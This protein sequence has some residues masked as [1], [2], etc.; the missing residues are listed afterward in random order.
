MQ[1]LSSIVR[2]F[3]PRPP[4]VPLVYISRPLRFLSPLINPKCLPGIP[5][6][7]L[8]PST[9]PDDLQRL[10]PPA[11]ES[12]QHSTRASSLRR[13]LRASTQRESHEN[14]QLPFFLLPRSLMTLAGGRAIYWANRCGDCTPSPPSRTA[15]GRLPALTSTTRTGP[16]PGRGKRPR[17][18]DKASP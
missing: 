15:T 13:P 14:D 5:Q 11:V 1:R 10:L 17:G 4:T 2:S 9:W 3:V 6:F 8:Y 7:P 12:S 18:A 16:V